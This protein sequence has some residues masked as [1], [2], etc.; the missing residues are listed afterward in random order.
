[1]RKSVDINDN[2][3]HGE[4]KA[5]MS[6]NGRIDGGGGERTGANVNVVA[7]YAQTMGT[8]SND[9]RRS[10]RYSPGHNG[11]RNENLKEDH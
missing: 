3:K 4:G 7:C 10:S 9:G 6:R 2:G 11:L 8:A 5:A 1:V